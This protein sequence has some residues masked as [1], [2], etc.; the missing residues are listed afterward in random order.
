MRDLFN[1]NNY[2]DSSFDKDTLVACSWA[3]EYIS[4][5]KEDIRTLEQLAYRIGLLKL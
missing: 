1:P 3:S 5:N 4:E 2:I